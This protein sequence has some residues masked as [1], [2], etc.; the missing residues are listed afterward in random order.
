[1][2]VP[3]VASATVAG[4]VVSVSSCVKVT[5]DEEVGFPRPPECPGTEG[6][7]VVVTVGAAVAV[8]SGCEVC[9]IAGP[10]GAGGRDV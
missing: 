2:V 7:V 3:S 5:T 1:M 9:V 4:T 6:R 10:L 8:S